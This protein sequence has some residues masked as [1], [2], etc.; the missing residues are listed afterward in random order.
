MADGIAYNVLT[1][2]LISVRTPEGEGIMLTLPG[3]LHRLATAEIEAFCALRRHQRQPW[4]CFLAQV[5]A[6]ALH[7]QGLAGED[8]AAASED[9]WREW[10]RALTD[11]QDEPWCLVVEDLSKPALLQPP[12]PEGA[13][14]KKGK[15]EDAKESAWALK[16]TAD[17]LDMLATAKSHD[18]KLATA[19]C[20]S[21]EVWLFSIVS[22]QTMDGYGGASINGIARM[23][24]GLGSRAFV[25]HAPSR[26]W[27][28]R[29][30]RDV[31][32]L[33][34]RRAAI[35]EAEGLAGSLALVWLRAWDGLD[36]IGLTELDPLF[37]EVCRRVRL[38]AH[39]EGIVARATG[40]SVPRIAAKERKGSLGDPWVPV[41]KEACTALTLSSQGFNYT[42]VVDLAFSGNWSHGSA[43]DAQRDD[44][45]LLLQ[46][47]TR[48]QGKTEGLH[49][50]WV[51][52]PS[53]I[54]ERSSAV[55]LQKMASERVKLA[56]E[57]RRA[58]LRLAILVLQQA[59][60]DKLKMD[61][62]T[63][64]PW[65]RIFDRRVDDGFFEQLWEDADR[66]PEDAQANWGR[67]LYARCKEVL[68]A[69]I[70][71]TPYSGPR[72]FRAIAAAE[73]VLRG[74]AYK[75]N[76]LRHEGEEAA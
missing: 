50:R 22:V 6:I 53:R 72:R 46:A 3:V 73:A 44:L 69:A 23:N 65:T 34:S 2:P 19:A 35:A 16:A 10:L 42:K 29:W 17:E 25:A 40:T 13:F 12:V 70:D 33:L 55:A 18:V 68:E 75:H 51:P 27:A 9:D 26:A 24:G 30:R 74:A 71:A 41:S 5:A 67:W 63:A 54:R 52:V 59:A 48:G 76:L 1:E 45:G 57:A 11:G 21:P 37:I 58:V 66:D 4:F 28:A 43:Y 39:G 56:A 61:A 64:D 7:R 60:P 32:R 8:S 38:V 15:K 49:E 20:A 14:A 62:K 47:M 36:S 31:S